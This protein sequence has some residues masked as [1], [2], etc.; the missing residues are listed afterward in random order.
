MGFK[1]ILFKEHYSPE[2]I[3]CIDTRFIVLYD[4]KEENFFYYGTRNVNTADKY[5][6]YD[7]WYHY[8]RLDSFVSF[9]SRVMGDLRH[10]ITVELHDIPILNTEYDYLSFTYLHNK[11]SRHTELCAYDTLTIKRSELFDWINMLLN[12]EKRL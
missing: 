1:A 11:F 7:G 9:L 10:K 4:S 8:S 5:T 3:G 2:D 6:D 12:N